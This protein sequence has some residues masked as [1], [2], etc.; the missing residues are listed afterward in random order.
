MDF[1]E[2]MCRI[3]NK[4]AGSMKMRSLK[5]YSRGGGSSADRKI[6]RF[7]RYF[8]LPIKADEAI[9]FLDTT[10]LKTAREGMLLTFSGILVK[11][12]LNKLYY[13]EYEKIKGAEVREVINEDGWLT[14][15]DLYVLFKDGT[16]RKLFDGYIKKEF[17]AE[18]INAVTALLNGS[19]HAGPEAG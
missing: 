17:F 2:D 6:E 5:W 8:V 15:T 12:P 11:E 14:G 16:E 19:D 7:I 3:F 4:Y 1:R 9:S 18:Y 10:V 13:L